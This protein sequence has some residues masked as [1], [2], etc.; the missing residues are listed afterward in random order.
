MYAAVG[1]SNHNILIPYVNPAKIR[2]KQE[3]NLH[4][5]QSWTNVSPHES[6]STKHNLPWL[7][8]KHKIMIK[9]N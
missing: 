6:T 7:Q 5:K 8:T 2:K 3:K 4:I 1:I 9:T